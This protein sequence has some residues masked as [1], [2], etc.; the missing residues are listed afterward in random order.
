M[1][2]LK[3]L[4]LDSNALTGIPDL[5]SLVNLRHLLLSRNSFKGPIPAAVT[6]LQNLGMSMI[7]A[8]SCFVMILSPQILITIFPSEIVFLSSNEFTGSLPE[9]SGTYKTRG[10]YLSDNKLSGAITESICSLTSLE[11]LF[12]DENALTGS[13]PA[14]IGDLGKLQQLHLFNNKLTG[15]IPVDAMAELRE[16][17]S[18]GLEKNSD[19]AGE[20]PE[21]FCEN[22]STKIDIWTDCGGV[23]A[24]VSCPCCSV[25]CPSDECV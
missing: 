7:I 14:C 21:D 25:C 6:Q 11:A 12:L 8:R 10:L 5:S 2:A 13:I 3:T 1:T 23:T 19:L 4:N 20:I 16:L 18:L 17:N 9:F 24:T 22:S 15:D